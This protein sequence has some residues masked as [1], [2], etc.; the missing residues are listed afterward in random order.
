MRCDLIDF[1]FTGL[2]H[3]IALYRYSVGLFVGGKENRLLR[4]VQVKYML[5]S[6]HSCY[7]NLC[8]LYTLNYF[9]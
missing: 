4:K 6:L 9:F 5:S 2:P 8:K 3:F 7:I 1:F